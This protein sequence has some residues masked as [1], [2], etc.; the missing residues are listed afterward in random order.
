MSE[1]EIS[2]MQIHI[3]HHLD[4]NGPHML[5]M[6]KKNEEGDSIKGEKHT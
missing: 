6:K 4:E 3:Q 2:Y 5:S 1:I